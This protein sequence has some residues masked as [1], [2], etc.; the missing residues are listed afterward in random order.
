VLIDTDYGAQG[1]WWVLTKE[2][3]ESPAPPGR[4]AGTRPSPRN[5][6]IKPWT[7][8]LSAELLDDLQ[9]WNRDWE[10]DRADSRELRERGRDL[11]VRVQDALGTDGWEVLYQMDGQML[12][13]HPPGSWPIESWRQ[14]L[15]DYAPR[16]QDQEPQD[17]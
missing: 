17:G 2:E 12:R 10:A 13:V 15:L 4:W 8:R 14:Q 11:A 7:D 3:K 16:P 1:I 6:R 9:Q 5:D